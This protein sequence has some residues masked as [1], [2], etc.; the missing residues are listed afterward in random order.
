MSSQELL[1]TV[2]YMPQQ[3]CLLAWRNVVENVSLGLEVRGHTKSLAIQQAQD[4]LAKFNMS[5]WAELY[6]HQLSGGM[7]QRVAFL[8][9][10]MIDSPIVLLDEPFSALD[11]LTRREMHEW[12][13]EVW[14][15]QQRTVLMIT[16][17]LEEALLLS[18]QILIMKAKETNAL[19]TLDIPFPR[20]RSP[21]LIFTESFSAW[22]SK[23][24]D[25]L[26]GGI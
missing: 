10:M 11:G 14:Q 3:D 18:D 20:P 8:R 22:K 26:G 7:R 9:T 1:G 4:F 17:D 6:P 15:I 2:V 19:V 24:Y 23:L 21:E 13:L 12:L 25:E 5:D 16:H